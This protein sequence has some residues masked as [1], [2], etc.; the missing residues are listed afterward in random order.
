[1]I[2]TGPNDNNNDKSNLPIYNLEAGV[3]SV[4]HASSAKGLDLDRVHEHVA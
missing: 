2:R 4:L 3:F 1:M